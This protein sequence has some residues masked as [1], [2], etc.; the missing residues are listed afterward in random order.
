[1]VIFDLLDSFSGLKRLELHQKPIHEVG[2]FYTPT[3]HQYGQW[4]QIFL[5]NEF[6]IAVCVVWVG[7][8]NKIR[9]ESIILL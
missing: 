2:G 3:Q 4:K 5:W 8:V 6:D 9:A 1:M 7:R